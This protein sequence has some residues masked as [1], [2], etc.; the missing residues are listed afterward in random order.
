MSEQGGRAWAWP[1][2]I[3]VGLGCVGIANAIMISIA[4]SHPSA[5]ASADHWAESLAWDQELELRERSAALGWSIAS[6]AWQDEDRDRVQLRL[7]DSAAR[8]L[9]GL[10]G[11]VTLE[12]SDTAAEDLRLELRELGEGR[13][14]ADGGTPTAGLVRL[15]LDVEDPRGERFVT[16]K[17]VA[18]GELRVLD[19]AGAS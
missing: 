12:R 19:D 16:R 11:S 4:L 13:Y 3:A 17:Q 7:I 10:R 5:P 2:G 6:I 18:L 14:V 15:T 8:P 1:V 9:L